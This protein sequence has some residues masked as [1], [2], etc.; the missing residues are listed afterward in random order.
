MK[1]KKVLAAA[2]VMGLLV[3]CQS[4]DENTSNSPS[5]EVSQ[6]EAVSIENEDTKSEDNNKETESDAKQEIKAGEEWIVDGQW[7]LKVNSVKSLEGRNESVEEQP[8]EVVMVDYSYE[9]LGYES[10]DG[11]DLYITP[12]RIIDGEGE[13]GSTYPAVEDYNSPKETPVGAKMENAQEAFGLNNESDKVK[14][15]FTQY[16]VDD[17]GDMKDYKVTVEADVE[18]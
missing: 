18:K 11:M 3:G 9:N 16:Y 4:E 1:F 8:A 17:N 2:M 13:M 7:K 12:D 10:E 5:N 15:I 6:E 14:V